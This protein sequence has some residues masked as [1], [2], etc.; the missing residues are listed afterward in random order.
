[1]P[2]VFLTIASPAAM[3]HLL[4]GSNLGYISAFPSATL[5]NFREEDSFLILDSLFFSKNILVV[6]SNP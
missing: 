6:G 2:P 1:M 5:Q 3:S 4:I